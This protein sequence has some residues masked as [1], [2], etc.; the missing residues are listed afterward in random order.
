MEFFAT[1]L[2]RW[3]FVPSRFGFAFRTA[4]GACLALVLAW[5][6]GLEHP[7]WSAMTVWAA[8]QPMRGMLIEKSLF[9]AVGTLF[10]TIV[11]VGL[12]YVANGD[13]LVLTLGIAIWVGL[14]T[15]VGNLL[16]GFVAYGA[17]LSGYS[18]SMV[19]LLGTATHTNILHLG[20]DRFFTVMVGVIMA[21]VVGL[22]FATASSRGELWQVHGRRAAHTLRTLAHWFGAP[23]DHDPSARSVLHNISD[24]A[25][26]L[27]THDAG[28]LSQRRHIKRLRALL[29]TQMD[30]LLDEVGRAA[31]R[32]SPQTAEALLGLAETIGK[33]DV[34][35]LRAAVQRVRELT[36]DQPKVQ[37]F[38]DA[39][40]QASDQELHSEDVEH[41]V[42]PAIHRDWIGA[43]NAAMRSLLAL[44]VVGGVWVVTGWSFGPYMML[45]TAVMVSLFS[46]WENPAAIMVQ[47]F[48]GQVAGAAMFLLVRWLVWPSADSAGMLVLQMLPFILLGALPLSHKKTMLGA[49]DFSL[50]FLLLAQPVY[51]LTGDFPH[52][53]YTALAVVAAPLVALF[54]FKFVYPTDAVARTRD[55]LSA[56]VHDVAELARKHD[57]HQRQIHWNVRFYYR[58][59]RLQRWANNAGDYGQRAIGRGLGLFSV[60][61]AVFALHALQ[62]HPDMSTS[63]KRLARLILGRLGNL[64]LV[65]SHRLLHQLAGRLQA[66]SPRDAA[67]LD[68]ASRGLGNVPADALTTP[69][70]P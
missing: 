66:V 48:F 28:S 63:S 52:T 55:V 41:M 38:L 32:P 23:L 56:M 19:A 61:E 13:P 9:R 17:L 57:P 16:R 50:V 53:L 58:L 69:A 62:H 44:L 64:E 30:L 31:A 65:A 14:C 26:A 37:T 6:I 70:A 7:Q 39:L 27:E 33:D 25:V 12:V 60:G 22:L 43:R 47:V 8:S 36:P 54:A 2:S 21:L 35:A 40:L 15:G 20:V 45:G 49:Y 4:F 10:G 24:L 34:G 1:T 18:A 11:G 46:T 67:V 3:G 68:A 5:A 51:P 59:L 29:I 42:Q